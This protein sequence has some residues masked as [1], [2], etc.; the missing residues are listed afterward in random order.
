MLLSK[1]VI[2][3]NT[4]KAWKT[5]YVS[6]KSKCIELSRSF[7]IERRWDG[8]EASLHTDTYDFN[9]I[10]KNETDHH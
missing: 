2:N 5:S 1:F 4:N 6:S 8:M 10:E 3:H 9:D 7:L